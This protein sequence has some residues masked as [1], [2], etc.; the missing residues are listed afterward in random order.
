[1]SDQKMVDDVSEKIK[2]LKDK[3]ES[4]K[5]ILI[6]TGT[7]PSYDGVAASLG[8]MLALEAAGKSVSC[9]CQAE[10]TVGFSDLFG[11]NKVKKELSGGSLA[12]SFDYVEGA[13]DKVSYNIENNKFNLV[14]KPKRGVAPL[15]SEK[16]HFSQQDASCDLIF[17]VDVRDFD[18]LGDLYKENKELFAS[19]MVV[20][21]DYINENKDFGKINLVNSKATSCSEVVAA[22]VRVLELKGTEDAMTNLLAG[23]DNKTKSLTSD[24]LS[25]DVFEAV[26]YLVRNGAKRGKAKLEVAKEEVEEGVVE[27]KREDLSFGRQGKK[28]EKVEERKVEKIQ[29][30]ERAGKEKK[31]PEKEEKKEPPDDWLTPKVYRG[32]QLL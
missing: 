25:A 16:V 28:E 32:G 20:N 5:E 4:A 29:A 21:I 19:S 6:L 8:L 11:V 15:S 14:I 30:A 26:A 12:I 1:M 9:A 2:E 7:N 23:V 13:V 22:L 18:D 17:T 24:L 27:E 3:I 10:M 31:E